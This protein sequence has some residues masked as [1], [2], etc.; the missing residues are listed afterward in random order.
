MRLAAFALTILLVP[1][2]AL[3]GPKVIT[4]V[5]P[6]HSIVA[7]VMGETGNPHLLL[8]G[9]MSEHRATFTATQIADLG[10]ADAVFIIGH[11]LEAKLARISGSEAVNGKRF[12]ELSDAPGVRTLPIRDGGGFEPHDHAHEHGD[13]HAEE[14]DAEGVLRFDP[15]VW[16]DPENA[17]AMAMA[18]AD[19]LSAA[20]P[21]N[22]AAYAANARTFAAG[23]DAVSAEIAASLAPVKDKPYIVFHDAYQYFERRFGLTAAG[24][25]ADVS[26]QPP[27]ARRLKEIRSILA[28]TGAVCVFRE[29]QYDDRM[30]N[31]VIE[32]SAARAGVLDPLGAGLTPGPG[33]Y[34]Q[35]LRDLAAALRACLA[36]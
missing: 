20:D 14:P 15:H 26:A 2:P 8:E 1:V 17:K 19:T 6:V 16:L 32:D 4:S 18:V 27:S 33:A 21:G 24:A 29:P 3:A 34:P 31:T 13:D 25:I 12:V 7:A 10:K 35:L 36:G 22:A 23:I 28:E 30:V 5:M 9:Q 11:G